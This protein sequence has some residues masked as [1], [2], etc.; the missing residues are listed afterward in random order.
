MTDE[1]GYDY[2][3]KYIIIGDVNV[4]KTNLLLRYAHG[5][6]RSDYNVTVGVEFGAKNEIIGDHIYRI[7]VYD[8]A[9]SENFRSVTR[10]YYK[11][12][13][14]AIIV[15]DI[16]NRESFNNVN[17]WVEDCKNQT[18]KT[19]QIVLV[20]NKTDL[21]D[22]RQVNTEEGE[23][24]AEKYG[25][26][27]K[28]TSAKTGENVNEILHMSAEEIAKKIEQDYYE[29]DSEDCG[30]KV[31]KNVQVKQTQN[32]KGGKVKIGGTKTPKKR[33]CC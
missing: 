3:L 27:F 11:S 15:Y 20:G 26:L 16:T 14:C 2:L 17:V 5:Q 21:E 9:G 13:V 10:T 7:Q 22:K 33:K 6:F 8:T 18:A 31:G 32:K 28:E 19:I 29:L 25:I 1:E 24:L 23:Q 30:I 4:G 12:S